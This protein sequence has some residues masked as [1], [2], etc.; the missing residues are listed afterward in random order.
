M[1]IKRKLDL[2]ETNHGSVKR[3]RASSQE[4][5][6]PQDM[7][8]IMN[9]LERMAAEAREDR[10]EIKKTLESLLRELQGMRGGHTL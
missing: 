8:T 2:E 9:S 4:D 1:S 3:L 10:R 7:V 5:I 6:Q